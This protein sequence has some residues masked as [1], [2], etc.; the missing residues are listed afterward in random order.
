MILT[1]PY[2][3]ISHMSPFFY[4]NGF[5][6][7]WHLAIAKKYGFEVEFIEPNGDAFLYLAQELIR[8][9]RFVPN[10]IL[11]IPYKVLIYL[12]VPL[13]KYLSKKDNST[14]KYLHFGYHVKMRKK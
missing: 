6:K 5:S 10:K 13:F 4:Y 3:S 7:N 2:C 9:T 11:K 12:L 8:T 1:A 14:N